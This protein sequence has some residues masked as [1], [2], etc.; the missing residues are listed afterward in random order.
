MVLRGRAL[1]SADE[2]ARADRFYF[3]RDQRRYIVARAAL[4]LHLGAEL[5]VDATAVSFVYGEHGKPALAP[6]Y[7][8][9]G[10][11]FNVSHSGEL[12]LFG[13]LR[14]AELGVD[15]E[16]HRP[17]SDRDALV[18]RYFSPGENHDFFALPEKQRQL[19]FFNC[20]TRKEAL[21]K[22]L[23]LGLSFSLRAFDVSLDPAVPARLLRLQQHSGEESGW[24]LAGFRPAEDYVAAVVVQGRKCT[25]I[26][27]T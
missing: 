14:D 5:G 23:G 25:V 15:L 4:R 7:S 12:G 9:S 17:L 18:R 20:W 1:L 8:D 10:L 22:A 13:V 3:P 24:C 11:K 21:I 2:C 16:V 6:P 19:G 27:A 26:R